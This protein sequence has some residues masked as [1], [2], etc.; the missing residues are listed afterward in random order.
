MDTLIATEK[1]V[2]LGPLTT[3]DLGGPAHQLLRVR[4][5]GEAVEAIRWWKSQPQPIPLM[6]LGGGSNILVS[7]SG[8]RGLVLKMEN[9]SIT[10]LEQSS[11]SILVEAGAG[12][13]WDDFVAHSVQQDWA[14]IECLSGIPGCVGAAPVQ[15]IGAYGQEVSETIERV[16][17]IDISSGE[18]FQYS[19]ADCG[20]AYRDSFF[21]QAEKGR[22]LITSVVFRLRPGGVPTI[23]YRDLQERCRA[24]DRKTL[25]EVRNLVL[26]IRRS[27]SMV[28]DRTDPNH[29]SAGSFFTNPIVA[30]EVADRIA[31][32]L[33][34]GVRFPRF[35]MPDGREKL[36]AAW[37]IDNAGLKKGFKLHGESKVGLSTKHVLALTNRGGGTSAELLELCRHVQ[38]VVEERFSVRLVP[39]P[40]FVGF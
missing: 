25:A 15:N 9:D 17:G 24:E 3:L 26:E 40:N 33:P 30:T 34:E 20:F 28:Y 38:A 1:M 5:Y 21:K 19:N 13:V 27:K 12:T 36:S 10:V 37:L 31:S 23:R 11:E 22:F 6:P 2:P 16:S 35:E 14:G 8:F 7:D 29:R 18:S 32:G 39:E 4:S